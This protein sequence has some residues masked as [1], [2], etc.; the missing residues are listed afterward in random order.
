MDLFRQSIVILNTKSSVICVDHFEEKFIKRYPKNLLLDWKLNPIPRKYGVNKP[1]LI[2]PS[3]LPNI[4]IK[5]SMFH[6]AAEDS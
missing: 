6:E 4:N 1:T 5:P 2:P 3:D